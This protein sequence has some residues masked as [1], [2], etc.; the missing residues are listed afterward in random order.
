[1]RYI[2]ACW[3]SFVL[4]ACSSSDKK[5]CEPGRHQA[6]TCAG[7]AIGAQKCLDD[8]SKW[9]ECDCKSVDIGYIGNAVDYNDMIIALQTR[10]IKSMIDFSKSFD[11]TDKTLMDKKH[12]ELLATIEG[13]LKDAETIKS[14]RDS[15]EFRDAA[16]EMFKF[17]DSIAKKEYL[18]IMNILKR[19][20]PEAKD[21]ARINEIVK[22]ISDRET[23]L[24][25]EF[26]K[27]QQAFARK[28]GIKLTD[29]RMQKQIDNL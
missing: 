4:V 29:N 24:D 17:Y 26:Q 21:L 20:K 1:M 6:C 5:V 15:T 3:L 12:A 11:S 8:G 10:I 9:G 16:M 23:K 18:E 14:F 25:S 27:I 7:G 19:D 22:S 13:V 28:H 2:L